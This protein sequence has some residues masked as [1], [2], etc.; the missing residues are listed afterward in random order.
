MKP[1]HF[2]RPTEH[3]DERITDINTLSPRHYLTMLQDCN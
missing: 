3:Y 1:I 2:E